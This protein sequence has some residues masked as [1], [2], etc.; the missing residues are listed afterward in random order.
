MTIVVKE[1]YF[2]WM[3][4]STGGVADLQVRLDIS[5]MSLVAP[6]T[7]CERHLVV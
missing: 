5:D 4:V 1:C 3:Q 6:P 2:G 7:I